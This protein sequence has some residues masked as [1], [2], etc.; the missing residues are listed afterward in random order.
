MAAILCCAQGAVVEDQK[1]IGL[2][3]QLRVRLALVIGELD[4]IG[5]VNEF[6]DSADMAAQKVVSGDICEERDNIF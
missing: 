5:A 2:K 4:L 1:L 3:R 6:D